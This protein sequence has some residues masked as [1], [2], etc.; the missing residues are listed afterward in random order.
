MNIEQLNP[1]QIDFWFPVEQ[2]RPLIEQI[3]QRVGLTRTR[4]E[5]FVRLWVYLVAKQRYKQPASRQQPEDIS[6][7]FALEALTPITDSIKCSHS[8]AAWLFY[9]DKDKGSD[10]AAGM[11][12]DKLAALGLLQKHFDGNT[13]RITIS[14]NSTDLYS[15]HSSP[16]HPRAERSRSPLITDDFNPRCDAVPVANLLAINYGWMNQSLDIVPHRITRLLRQ[17]AQQYPIGMRVL[18]RTDN[19]NPVG[20]YLLYPTTADSEI[21]FS[22]SP[23]K[24]LHLASLNDVDPF[25]LA[26]PGDLD[27]MAVFIRSWMID[28][29][30]LEQYRTP[31]LQDAQRTLKKMQQD[32][33]NLC[34]LYT[35]IIHPS[36][37]AMAT[38]VGFQKIGSQA[39]RDTQ[40]YWMYQALD[41]YLA[42]DLSNHIS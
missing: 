38:A 1:E 17:W 20:F 9:G 2:Q 34:D 25:T 35:L 22:S 28:P 33:P 21:T 12:L 14:L 7:P 19:L 36:Y 26:A 18:R 13:T 41:R 23:T 4:A 24:G 6:R 16:N 42:L 10:R 29:V 11:M 40:I 32:F 27:C 39:H 5:Y 15:E 8:E 31:F 37:E 30:Y 3:S